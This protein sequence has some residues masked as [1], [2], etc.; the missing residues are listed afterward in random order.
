MNKTAFPHGEFECTPDDQI[1]SN[2]DMVNNSEKNVHA[3]WI[4][5]MDRI[6]D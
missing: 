3:Y 4:C 2:G 1:I 6:D 5:S